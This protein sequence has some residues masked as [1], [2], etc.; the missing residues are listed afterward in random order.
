MESSDVR[1]LLFLSGMLPIANGKLAI[2]GRLGDNLSVEQGREAAL[3]ASLNTLAVAKEHLVVY[4]IGC[5]E[6]KYGN[7]WLASYLI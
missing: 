2:S 7:E 3:M 5:G 6:P 1:N 4:W